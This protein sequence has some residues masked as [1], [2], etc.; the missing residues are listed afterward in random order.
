MPINNYNNS[1][2]QV[3]KYFDNILNISKES[4][5]KYQYLYDELIINYNN[6][7]KDFNY[8]YNII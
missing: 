7:V 4:S 3:K 2:N 1:L 5:D 6:I 8:E